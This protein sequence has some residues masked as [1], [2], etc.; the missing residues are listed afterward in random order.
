MYCKYLLTNHL[1]PVIKEIWPGESEFFLM[2]F[3]DALMEEEF[4]NFAQ[5]IILSDDSVKQFLNGEYEITIMLP[6]GYGI[7]QKREEAERILL[8]INKLKQ[9][10]ILPNAIDLYFSVK[11]ISP[12]TLSGQNT[13]IIMSFHNLE[14]LLTVDDV[15]CEMKII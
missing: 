3:W 2:L 6:Y 13:E 7:E 9:D 11:D 5:P 15:L 4:S 12:E 1:T 14:K 8:F 10:G